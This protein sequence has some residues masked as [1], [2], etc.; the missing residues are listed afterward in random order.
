MNFP[1][2]RGSSLI[3]LLH[4]LFRGG[5]LSG[6]ILEISLRVESCEVGTRTLMALTFFVKIFCCL[7]RENLGLKSRTCFLEPAIFLLCFFCGIMGAKITTSG[8]V[9]KPTLTLQTWF[10][11]VRHLPQKVPYVPKDSIAVNILCC[12]VINPELP[13]LKKHVAMVCLVDSNI[14]YVGVQ[15]CTVCVVDRECDDQNS[16][17]KVGE[18]I[19][20]TRNGYPDVCCIR[21]QVDWVVVSPSTTGYLRA[22]GWFL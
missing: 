15:V 3:I 11:R 14:V 10:L 4:R 8:V 1:L 16:T 22:V 21:V 5:Y 20:W 6:T 18:L 12:C 7:H 19:V 2:R 13:R 9:F 17:K